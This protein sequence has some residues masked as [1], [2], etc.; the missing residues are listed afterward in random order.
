[1]FDARSGPWRQR[2]GGVCR[3]EKRNQEKSGGWEMRSYGAVHIYR[4]TEAERC[5]LS[6][7]YRATAEWAMGS[8]EDLSSSVAR[9]SCPMEHLMHN[10][11]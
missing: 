7:I 8:F 5:M 4:S 1:V 6:P 2:D 9:A 11:S 3:R 10:G